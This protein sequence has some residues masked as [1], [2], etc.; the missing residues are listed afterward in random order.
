MLREG[1]RNVHFW[2]TLKLFGLISISWSLGV[3]H[4][5]QYKLHALKLKNNSLTAMLMSPLTWNFG[6][7]FG[8]HQFL[9]LRQSRVAVT[10]WIIAAQE[11]DHSWTV[12]LMNYCVVKLILSSIWSQ[13]G[14]QEWH[15]WSMQGLCLFLC[16]KNNSTITRSLTFKSR[17]RE[18]FHSLCFAT[19]KIAFPAFCAAFLG[20]YILV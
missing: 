5:S 8:E 19:C 3:A 2:G 11:I 17:L 14:K 4:S 10:F 15:K 12:W 20:I 18:S 7:D 1:R 16:F 13:H 9:T 6:V